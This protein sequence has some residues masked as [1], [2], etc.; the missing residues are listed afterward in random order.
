MK[1]VIIGAGVAGLSIGWRLAQA[2]VDVTVLER[3]QP[4]SG[5]SW[6]AAG[7]IA[8]TAELMDADAAEI[9]FA[10]YSNDL[11]QDFAQTLEAVSGQAVGYSQSGALILAE[12]E[13]ALARLSKKAD[14]IAILSPA[15]VRALAPLATGALAGALWS[16]QEAHVDSRALGVALA[17]AYQLAGGRLIANEAVVRIERRNGR[18]AIAHTPFGLY[19]ADVF[20]L[21]AGAWS[22]LVE[23]ELAPIT[24]VKGEMIALAPPQGA[25][26]PGPV[27]WGQGIYAVP[28]NGRLLIGATMESV[29]FDTSPTDSA[30]EFLRG[31]AEAAMPGL[32]DW[33]LVDHWA[34]LRPRSSDGLPLLGP[35]S[36]DG[37]WLAGG[38]FRN[39]IL[40][41]PAIA[42]NIAAQ[43]MG[44]AEPIAAFDPRRM[45]DSNR[46]M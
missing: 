17:F 2:G 6:A 1:V 43:L 24:P 22:G 8:V 45:N 29:G 5:A 34:G 35:T 12:D 14:G 18:A 31:R 30:V 19:H 7:M 41:A 4:A 9:E 37:L 42:E 13:A 32:R 25:L 28:R 21:A 3:A 26:L 40:F 38:Q 23:A 39:G 36:L 11:W 10:R 20:V 44:R 15:E 16:P 33:S 46:K 27:I